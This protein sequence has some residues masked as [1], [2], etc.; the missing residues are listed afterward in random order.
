M[1]RQRLSAHQSTHIAQVTAATLELGQVTACTTV[2]TGYE[3]TTILLSARSGRHDRRYIIK[4]FA[5]RAAVPGAAAG[6]DPAYRAAALIQAARA[7]GIRHPRLHQIGGHTVHTLSDGTRYLVMDHVAGADFYALD[8]PPTPAET[9][10]LISQLAVFHSVDLTPEPV[11]DP[12]AIQQLVPTAAAVRGH[13]D[14]EMRRLAD[15]A[16]DA[17]AAIDTRALPHAL[18]HGDL[19]KGNV[20]ITTTESPADSSVDATVN[21][22]GGQVVLIDF[23]AAGRHPRI[24]EL[25]VA[26]ANLTSAAPET[27][28]VRLTA[29]AEQYARHHPLTAA[30]H[31]A[32]PAYGRA[33]ATMEFLGAAR[34]YHLRGD[35]CTE[36]LLLLDIGRD[37]MRQCAR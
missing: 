24:Q 26:A 19:T 14:P 28:P 2:T 13:L 1:S 32:L 31:A 11:C 7:A 15:A 29:L 12:W 22:A 5:P 21:E 23:G 17:M 10:D 27:L 9:A 33:A 3:D 36:T 16:I 8:R 37:G 34:E 30:E 18:I 4:T 20:L 25:A 6:P 35:R